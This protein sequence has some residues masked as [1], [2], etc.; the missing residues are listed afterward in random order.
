MM[1]RVKKGIVAGFVA[2]LVISILEAVNIFAL[3]S[4]FQPFPGMVASLL[5]MDGNLAAGWAIHLFS[6]TFILGSLFGVLCPRL[7]T[8]TA[9]TKGIVFAV[10]A[11]VVMMLGVFFIGDSQ[12]LG[13]NMATLGWMLVTHIVFGI[14]LGTV[15]SRLVEREKRAHAVVGAHPAH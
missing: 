9:E 6:G 2:T 4:M 8:D 13:S 3:N 7:P 12:V 10:G 5:G 14:V 11:W 15:Y 1:S